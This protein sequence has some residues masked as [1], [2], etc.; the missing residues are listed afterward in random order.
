MTAGEFVA[1]L[2]TV[3]LPVKFPAASGEKVTSN[4]ATCPGARI[5]P[6]ETPLV[7][8]LV[9]VMP[10]LEIVTSEFPA[11]DSATLK[12]LLVPADTFPKLKLP[13]P[14]LR[15]VVGATPVPLTVMLLGELDALL[16]TE[17]APETAPAASGEN[18]T[19]KLDWLPAAIVIGKEAPVIVTPLVAVPACVTVRSDPPPLDTVTDCETAPPTA[20]D[21]K[22]IDPGDTEIVATAGAAGF[23]AADEF[24]LP[25]VP[26]QPEINRIP[27]N[28]RNR[29]A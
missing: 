11:F 10:T 19:L 26:T 18:T 21:P 22:V 3:T 17:T 5:I 9:P 23:C 6:V 8:I 24:P 7:V 16:I 28:R 14:A 25:V 2:A 13:A 27:D 4:V 15:S 20:T 1:L 29:A 12:V